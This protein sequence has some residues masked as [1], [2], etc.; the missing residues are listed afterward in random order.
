MKKLLNLED[1]TPLLHL[2]AAVAD[3]NFRCL[4]IVSEISSNGR[5]V[6]PDFVVRIL[7]QRYCVREFRDLGVGDMCDIPALFL[8]IEIHQKV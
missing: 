8:L 6:T 5:M 4:E 1:L 3:V 2:M 7:L